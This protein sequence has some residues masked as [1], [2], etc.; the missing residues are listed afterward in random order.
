MKYL[1]EWQ[2]L[3]QDTVRVRMIHSIQPAVRFEV[4]ASALADPIAPVRT[5]TSW[6]IG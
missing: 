3:S 5:T 4:F 2:W 6:Q 1:L